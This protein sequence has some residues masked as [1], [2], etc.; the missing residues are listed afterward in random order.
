MHHV[1]L[2]AQLGILGCLDGESAI[3]LRVVDEQNLDHGQ[4]SVFPA[5]G[6]RMLN[7]APS[8][9]FASVG[10]NPTLSSRNSRTCMSSSAPY[11]ICTCGALAPR[12][13][14][15]FDDKFWNNWMSCMRSAR[16]PGSGVWHSMT[17][18]VPSMLNARFCL[19][20]ARASSNS[21]IS[22][23]LSLAVT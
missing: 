23:P 22:S 8:F 12:N 11:A 20:R 14:I 9:G 19:A 21:T 4:V 1:D 15:A 16:M 10:L 3:K 17:A 6:R 7:V 18:S 13:L 5:L 2:V